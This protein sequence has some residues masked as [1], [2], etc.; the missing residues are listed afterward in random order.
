MCRSSPG[1]KSSFHVQTTL[2]SVLWSKLELRSEYFGRYCRNRLSFKWL[3]AYSWKLKTVYC[4]LDVLVKTKDSLLKLKT[5]ANELFN[6]NN[7]N[8][9]SYSWNYH[10][11]WHQIYPHINRSIRPKGWPNVKL[12]WCSTT[13]GH[14]MPVLGW[15]WGTEGH[16]G[17]WRWGYIWPN[18]SLTHSLTKCHAELQ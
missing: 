5:I 15:G 7:F 14:K 4:K 11:C 16:R 8:I 17:W 13:L 1:G 3:K 9:C 18:L 12:T 6:W 2:F 10:G